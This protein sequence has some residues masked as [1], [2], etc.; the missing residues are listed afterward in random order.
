MRT[1]KKWGW[2]I[3]VFHA[4]RGVL[5]NQ[6]FIVD[7]ILELVLHE[8]GVFAIVPIEPTQNLYRDKLLAAEEEL[9]G[10]VAFANRQ[11]YPGSAMVGKLGNQFVDHLTADADLAELGA[12]P[13]VEQMEPRAVEFINH[14]PNHPFFVLSDHADAIALSKGLEEILLGPRVIKASAFD[15]EYFG[16]VTPD[17]PADMQFD[18]IFGPGFHSGSPNREGQSPSRIPSLVSAL[19]GS[20]PA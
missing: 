17:H 13:K 14:E 16:H 4:D 3:L 7:R 12:D 2:R 11:G 1:A 15:G 20:W 18:L 9:G 10:K 5:G 6:I 19:Q 8:V